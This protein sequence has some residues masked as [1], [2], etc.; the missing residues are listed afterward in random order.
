MKLAEALLLRSDTQKKIMSLR[1]R[2]AA[3]AMVQ[4][5][6]SPH[7]E[8]ESLINEASNAT[9]QLAKIIASINYTNLNNTLEDGRT[10]T[11][12][13]ADRDA[14]QQKHAIFASAIDG[15]KREANRYSGREIKWVSALNV[16][17][18]HKRS[19]DVSKQLR[20]LNAKIQEANWRIELDESRGVGR[21]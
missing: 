6:D 3:N 17:S 15:T 12:A 19:D 8:P 1:E 4:E 20:E 21:V 5:G 7:E 11:D 2:I 9:E 10:L 14:L 18:L 16:E 13:I